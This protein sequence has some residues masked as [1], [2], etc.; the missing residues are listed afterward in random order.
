[1]E[2]TETYPLSVD[3]FVVRV[4]SQKRFGVLSS[5]NF[6]NLMVNWVLFLGAHVSLLGRKLRM[7]VHGIFTVTFKAITIPLT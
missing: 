2:W 3:S 4:I 6:S 1:M 5:Q 7:S